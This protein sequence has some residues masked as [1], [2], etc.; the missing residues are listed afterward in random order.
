MNLSI[1]VFHPYIVGLHDCKF[2][3]KVLLCITCLRSQHI[4]KKINMPHNA[5]KIFYPFCTLILLHFCSTKEFCNIRI[6]QS[7]QKVAYLYQRSFYLFLTFL[8]SP[9][10]TMFETSATNC[11]LCCR[12]FYQMVVSA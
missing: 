7:A 4:C 8:N 1:G 12:L 5:G 2:S 6:F 10:D 11:H 9:C 3:Q